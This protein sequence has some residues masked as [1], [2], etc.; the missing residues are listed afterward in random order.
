M[1]LTSSASVRPRSPPSTRQHSIPVNPRR[2]APQQAPH[3]ERFGRRHREP[4]TSRWFP[5]GPLQLDNLS[6]LVEML[7]AYRVIVFEPAD[8]LGHQSNHPNVPY[9][10]GEQSRGTKNE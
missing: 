7:G 2:D 1:N 6:D 5:H 9:G 4:R 3:L 10:V 8:P